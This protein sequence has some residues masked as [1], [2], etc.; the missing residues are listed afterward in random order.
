MNF[1]RLSNQSLVGKILRQPLKLIPAKT[2]LRILQGR[3]RGKHWIAGSSI[4]GCWLGSYENDKQRL[5]ES[6]MMPGDIVFDIGAN[7][8]FYT[9]L[10][11]ELVG[12]KGHVYSFE[13]VPR[14]INFLKEH[15]RLNQVT[16]TTIIET[17][18]SDINGEAY[19]DDSPNN[20]MGR[21]AISG[22]RRVRTVTIDSLVREGQLPRPDC[23]KI[24]VEGA[25]AQ[26]LAGAQSTLRAFH[27][28]IFLATHGSGPHRECCEQLWSLGYQLDGIGSKV[29]SQCDELFAFSK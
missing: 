24:D 19:F 16:N 25:E 4:H 28:K 27:P 2:H 9:L 21:L 22:G 20:S 12:P 18:V 26:V 7:V 14:N 13:P 11:S 29:I 1:S 15:L 17:A 23:L 8:G 6:T 5:V 3:L 10:A